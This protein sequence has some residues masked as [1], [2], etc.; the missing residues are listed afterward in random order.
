MPY[1]KIEPQQVQ[2]YPL[3][4][5]RSKSSIT[6]VLVDPDQPPPLQPEM[7]ALVYQ[8][9]ERIRA[10]RE[11]GAAV[12]L[13][14]GAHLVKNGLAS[15]VIRL[16]EEGWI[17]HIAGN[18]ACT[19]HDWEFAW[20]GKSEEDVRENVAA[21]CF[22]TWEETGRFINLAVQANLLR[23]MGYGE[24]IGALIEEEKLFL[25]SSDEL[26]ELLRSESDLA[27]AAADLLNTLQKFRLSAGEMCIPHPF[28][29][30]SI[31]GNA[32][33]MRIPATVHPGIGYDIIYNNPYAN[34]AAI[35][36][37]AHLDYQVFVHSV[38]G[39]KGGVF[40]SVGSAIM[41]PQIFE[42]AL[43]FANNLRRQKGQDPITDLTIFVN[44]LQPAAWDWSKGEPP[45]NSP[46]Y[47]FRFLKSFYRM[48]GQVFYAA[49]DNREFLGNL[50]K[51][52]NS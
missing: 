15:V 14:F 5:R 24:A 16:L 34:G 38:T 49:G 30:Y 52:L 46:D 3:A 1:P 40:L 10:A 36:R 18:G 32:F 35:G 12:I 50:Y 45:K 23:G 9:A 33:R 8:A 51:R 28:K 37:A 21:G 26:R 19:I 22:G 43:S 25:P 6:E 2:V 13:A 31:F 29:Q 48:E 41:A 4:H 20:F 7:E 47:Y 11:R 27:S 17:T 42:K 39:L 44:D